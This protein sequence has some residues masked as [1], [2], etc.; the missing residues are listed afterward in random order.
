MKLKDIDFRVWDISKKVFYNDLEFSMLPNSS[1][2][3]TFRMDLA[4]TFAKNLESA[5]ML[6]SNY[7]VDFYTGFRD[8]NGKKIYEG[9]ILRYYRES[10]YKPFV[11]YCVLCVDYKVDFK[12]I[13]KNGAGFLT[14]AKQ[15]AI[16][17]NSEIIGNIHESKDL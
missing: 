3:K 7:E 2:S 16:C 11:D 15:E 12:A 13:N 5:C 10:K 17:L 9:D 4:I 6:S 8:R 14:E 1:C